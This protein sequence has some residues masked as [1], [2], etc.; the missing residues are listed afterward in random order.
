MALLDTL[1]DVWKTNKA[2][3]SAGGRDWKPRN[4]RELWTTQL[5]FDQDSLGERMG[6]ANRELTSGLR[7]QNRMD[8]YMRSKA[9]RDAIA[10]RQIRS[11]DFQQTLGMNELGYHQQY[12]MNARSFGQNQLFN[13]AQF[14]QNQYLEGMRLNTETAGRAGQRGIAKR[15]ELQGMFPEA[16][17][18]DLMGTSQNASA[19]QAVL[20]GYPSASSANNAAGPS[21]SQQ[22]RAHEVASAEKIAAMLLPTPAVKTAQIA[23]DA[24]KYSAA[25]H[26][27]SGLG[28]ALINAQAP[29]RMATVAGRKADY[30]GQRLPSDIELNRSRAQEAIQSG[31]EKSSRYNVNE[32]EARVK[33]GEADSSGRYYRNRADYEGAKPYL[34]VFGSAAGGLGVGMAANAMNQLGKRVFSGSGSVV[35]RGAPR[36]MPSGI[37]ASGPNRGST[38]YSTGP[39]S[40]K[41]TYVPSNRSLP[42]GNSEADTMKM[43]MMMMGM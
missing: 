16:S 14:G 20:P 33:K 21:P 10:A 8:F 27:M 5:R 40:R 4:H 36:S 28:E 18:W 7:R 6:L 2:S 31:A 22:L 3:S 9:M 37:G 26:A 17:P 11:K 41:P 1:V 23:A 38:G 34:D 13:Q 42:S 32:Q 43:L 15:Q 29:G 25:V 35:R 24:Q 12:G 30:E 39:M 19:G